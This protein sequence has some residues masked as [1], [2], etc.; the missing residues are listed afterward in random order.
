VSHDTLLETRILAAGPATVAAAARVLET[1]G[2]A[3]FP[4]E[5]VYGLGARA[6]DPHAV[7]RL[8]AAEGRPAF[9][10]LIAHVRS[11]A[12]AEGLAEFNP[13]AE[14]LAAQFWPGPLTLVLRAKG[15]AV[16]ELARAG[17]NTVAVRVPSHPVARELLSLTPFA[18]VAPSAN[19]SGHVSPTTAQHVHDDLGGRIDLILDGGAA[20]VGIESAIVDCSGTTP[21]LLRSGGL[22]R[23]ALEAIAGPLADA[24]ADRVSAPGMLASHYAPR[25]RLR[26]DAAAV[27]DGEALL[28]FGPLPQGAAHAKMVLNLSSDGDPVEAAANLYA[29]LRALDASG[30]RTIAVT[31]IP[32]TGLGEAIRDRLQR[33]AAPR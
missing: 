8:Y 21:V 32:S 18:V 2:L 14:R 31:P 9:N 26:L 4:T 6:D 3:A 12:A 7:A 5:T 11:V 17:L 1:G 30:A 23:A 10:P 29:Y 19:R 24:K 28:A 20:P 27:H 13:L 22:A 16:C 25:A 33:A 15:E